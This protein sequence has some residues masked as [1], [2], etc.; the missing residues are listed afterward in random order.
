MDGRARYGVEVFPV[1]GGHGY[2]YQI[3]MDGGT[4]IHQPHLPGPSGRVPF[5]S[6][7]DARRVAELMVTRMRAG[8][9]PPAVSAEDLDSLGVW[10]PEAR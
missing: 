8:V 7:A 10:R 2:G 5:A 9:F 3:S 1:P 6:E 4:V